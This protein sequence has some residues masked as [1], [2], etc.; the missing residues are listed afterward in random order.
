MSAMTTRAGT[1]PN[2]HAPTQHP[3]LRRWV[4]EGVPG[5]GGQTRCGHDDRELLGHLAGQAVDRPLATSYEPTRQA[6][7]NVLARADQENATLR[8][9]AHRHRADRVVRSQDPDQESPDLRRGSA[10]HLVRRAR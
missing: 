1:P 7:A 2:D 4:D 5:L 3:A 10:E 6:P 8:V 9:L